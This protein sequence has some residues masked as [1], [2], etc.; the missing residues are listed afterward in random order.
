MAFTGGMRIIGR[1]TQVL[2]EL[3]VLAEELASNFHCFAAKYDVINLPKGGK[4]YQASLTMVSRFTHL[5]RH[6]LIDFEI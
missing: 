2:A 1:R 6:H 5:G 4:P 3:A